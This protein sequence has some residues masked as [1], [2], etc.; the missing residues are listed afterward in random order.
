MRAARI[1]KNLGTNKEERSAHKIVELNVEKSLHSSQNVKNDLKAQRETIY[2]RLQERKRL[3]SN[4]PT[5]K[6][7]TRCNSDQDFRIKD[8]LVASESDDAAGSPTPAF[9]FEEA[10]EKLMEQ[11]VE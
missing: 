7:L 1:D 11:H 5:S 9:D 10:F 3:R 4:T 2:S 6:G 8:R